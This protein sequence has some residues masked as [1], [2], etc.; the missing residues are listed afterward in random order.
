MYLNDFPFNFGEN[1]LKILNLHRYLEFSIH[2]HHVRLTFLSIQKNFLDTFAT[3]SMFASS[4]EL[5]LKSQ[6]NM[7]S[8]FRG[9]V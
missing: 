4:I 8:F 6:F 2:F 5:I 7:Y 1:D 9:L 3:M